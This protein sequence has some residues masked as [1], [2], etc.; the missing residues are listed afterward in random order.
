M[1]MTDS[2]FSVDV[3]LVQEDGSLG[4][5]DVLAFNFGGE[6][7]RDAI[8]RLGLDPDMVERSARQLAYDHIDSE[9]VLLSDVPPP[10][11]RDHVYKIGEVHFNPEN[12]S[13]VEANFSEEVR[14]YRFPNKDDES[15][16][17]VADET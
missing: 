8:S 13:I 17:A 14:G 2:M 16:E 11:N 6:R 10:S 9:N 1:S 3:A 4:E 15:G 5:P 7:L 12:G